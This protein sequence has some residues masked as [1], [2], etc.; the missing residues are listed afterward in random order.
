MLCYEFREDLPFLANH[1]ICLIQLKGAG[2]SLG[3]TPKDVFG[4]VQGG[5]ACAWM[6]AG[7]G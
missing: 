6:L 3:N 5:G 7:T 2:K 1:W 4:A